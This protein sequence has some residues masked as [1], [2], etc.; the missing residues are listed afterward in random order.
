MHGPTTPYQEIVSE[1]LASRLDIAVHLREELPHYW[2]EDYLR[3]SSRVSNIVIFKYE[4]FDYI[5]DAYQQAEPYSPTSKVAPI[6][7]RLVA[8]IGTSK[9]RRT[10][11]DDARL[12]GI[13]VSPLPGVKGKWD[14]GHFIAHSIGGKVDGNEA[15]VFLQLR[16]VNR[17]RYRRAENYCKLNPGVTCFSRPIYADTSAHPESIEFGVLK[18]NGELWV[19]IM[20]NR[21]DA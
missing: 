19:E 11:R 12:R 17:G 6:D 3:M 18:T 21:A 1:A 9:P 10:K 14:R 13:S 20:P 7:A 8:V 15:N 2:R 16:S 5:F 4:T